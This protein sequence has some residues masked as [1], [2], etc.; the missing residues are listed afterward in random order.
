MSLISLRFFDAAFFCDRLVIGTLTPVPFLTGWHWVSAVL[1]KAVSVHV[2]LGILHIAGYG[3][4]EGFPPHTTAKFTFM[5]R[6]RS[7]KFLIC[8]APLDT[9]WRN[10]E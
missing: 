6:Y 7:D 5:E 1:V 3:G 9:I 4:G 2:W 8:L 10:V